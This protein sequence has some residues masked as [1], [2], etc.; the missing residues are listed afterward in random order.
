MRKSSV[1]DNKTGKSVASDIRTSTGMFFEKGEDEIIR[2]VEKRVS[3]VTMVPVEHQE[4]IQVLHYHDG[5]KYE[6][7]Y[8]YFHDPVNAA[9]SR[10]GQRLITMLIYL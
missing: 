3:Q 7:H 9:P 4:G 6:P 8:D 2:R 1:V 5:Q 10:G